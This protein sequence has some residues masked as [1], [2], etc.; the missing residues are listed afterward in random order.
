M[1]VKMGGAPWSVRVPPT[2]DAMTVGF[3]IAKDS[4]NTS[5]RYSCMV[6]TKDL[7]E[8]T[9]FFSAV[10]RISG[11]DCSR[12]NALNLLKAI[13][14]YKQ[15]HNRLPKYIF[16][17]RGGVGDGDLAF[18]RDTE[19]AVI[20]EAVNKHCNNEPPQMV[21]IV[22]NKRINTRFWQRSGERVTNPEAG[23]VIDNDITLPE[24][25]EFFLV[26]QKCGQ[27]TISPTNY[28]V[29]F[30]NTD[31][32]PDNIQSWTYIQTHL[33]FNWYGTTQIPSVLQYA[34]KLGF[35]VAN[36]MH[37][38]PNESLCERLFFL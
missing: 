26:S 16:I 38:V 35:L 23:T 13:N 17:Y 14:A 5:V 12:E 27:G 7:R 33:Y 22:V 28:N 4:N 8:N 20:N 3:D 15:E 1:C 31:L 36:Y 9:S 32:K 25:Y 37:R 24:R 11:S 34:N 19:L 6:A 10:S 29:L 30:D 2:V 21:F 18:V